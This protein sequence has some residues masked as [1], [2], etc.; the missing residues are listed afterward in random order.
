M[1]YNGCDRGLNGKLSSSEVFLPNPRAKPASSVTCSRASA[2]IPIHT[3]PRAAGWL[4]INMPL[5]VYDRET[6]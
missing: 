3:R 4:L 5:Y 1:F 6:K 2:F